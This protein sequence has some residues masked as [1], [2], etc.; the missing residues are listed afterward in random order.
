MNCSKKIND[1]KIVLIDGAGKTKMCFN[2]PNKRQITK[3]KVDNCAITSGI[4][5]DFMLVDHN[6]LEHYIELKGKQII[7]ACNQIEETI[8]RLSK[9]LSAIKH[10]FI[11]STACPLTTTEVQVLKANFK[12]KYNS[13]LKVKN[14]FC[15]HRFE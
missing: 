3:I 8:K 4:R 15:E 11:V 9:N 5:C 13:T 14:M 10:S 12:K 1:A 2:N 7:H 6:S